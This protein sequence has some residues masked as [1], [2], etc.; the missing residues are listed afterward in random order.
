[1]TSAL[2]G[3]NLASK[4]ILQRG[5]TRT[6]PTERAEQVV[7]G[8]AMEAYDAASNGNR[9]RGGMKKASDVYVRKELYRFR[10]FADLL[11]ES[12]P[13]IPT[14]QGVRSSARQQR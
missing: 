5:Q 8:K 13:S 6:L 12:T 3:F 4:M 9:T 11:A 7:L 10:T 1:M 2:T 14:S